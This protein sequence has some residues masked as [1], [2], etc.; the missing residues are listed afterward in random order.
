MSARDLPPRARVASMT[1]GDLLLV[2]G[3]VVMVLASF[4]P[5][6]SYD[7][8]IGHI[9]HTPW[10]RE[11]LPVLLL[12]Y[13]LGAAVGGYRALERLTSLSLPVTRWG[14]SSDQ[15][16]GAGAVVSTAQI[17]LVLC[18]TSSASWG[19]WLAVCADAAL[20]AGTVLADRVPG[21]ERT[22]LPPEAGGGEPLSG[23]I[24][25]AASSGGRQDLTG[26]TPF[27][28]CVRGKAAA[29][30]PLTGT[31]RFTLSPGVWY[32]ATAAL[33]NGT[34]LEVKDDECGTGVLRDLGLVQRA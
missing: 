25:G 21:L 31:V 6:L 4:L 14:W 26:A 15:L 23:R 28:F 24:T 8:I 2:A 3:A 29:H 20:L 7:T 34:A 12:G 33:E 27:W 5:M 16:V 30:D 9:S 22:V 10:R 11:H 32:L 1:R 18:S 17:F 13:L 19:L